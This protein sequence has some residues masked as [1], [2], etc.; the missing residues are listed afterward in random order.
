MKKTNAR[1]GFFSIMF[2]VAFFLTGNKYTFICIFA[3]AL[4]ELGH[5]I[6]AYL[7]GIKISEF[8]FGV[9]GARMR[10]SEGLHS[11]KKEMLLSLAGPLSNFIFAFLA[12]VFFDGVF[13]D[14][15]I[16][17]SIFLAILN[18]FPIRTFDGG[19]IFECLLLLFLPFSFSKRIVDIS[20][21]IFVFFLWS[22]SVYF[23]LIYSSSINLFIFSA[24]IFS[25]LFISE[26][27]GRFL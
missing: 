20:S 9:L 3:A 8:T 11:Y 4:H 21:F 6:A 10:I 15:F 23:L 12:C 1:L 17:F 14:I 24:S 5:L 18:L 27:N 13:V 25:S 7:L 22:V 2:I 16:A 19:R 26:E